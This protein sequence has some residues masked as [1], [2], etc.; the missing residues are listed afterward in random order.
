MS[1]LRTVRYS[2]SPHMVSFRVS[3]K[4]WAALIQRSEQPAQKNIG[5]ETLFSQPSVFGCGTD[6]DPTEEPG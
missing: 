2:T 4:A 6:T 3:E 5:I 1:L